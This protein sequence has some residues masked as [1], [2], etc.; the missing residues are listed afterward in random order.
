MRRGISLLIGM[1]LLAGCGL[2]LDMGTQP[3]AETPATLEE[4]EDVVVAEG[5]VEP[6]H[7]SD[8]GFA[9]AGQVV[10]VLVEEGDAVAARD[11]L[12]RLDQADARLAVKQAEA[13]L[14]VAEAQL[15][16]LK[17]GAQPEEIAAAEARLEAAEA[18]VKQATAERDRVVSGATE[19]EIAAA[20]A[21]VA[22]ADTQRK[23]AQDTYDN[24][25]PDEELARYE[26]HAARK[27][28]TAAQAR[29]DDL[30][31]GPDA[32]LF[33][34]VE[35][36]VE[37]AAAERDAVQDQLDLVQAG[38]TEEEIAI[39]EVDVA[40]ARVSL[41]TAHAALADAE[42]QAPFGGTVTAVAVEVGN[43]VMPG[44]VACTLAA[45]DQLQVRTKDLSELDVA[46][47]EPGQ[48]VKVTVDALPEREFDGVVRRVALQAEDFRGEAVFAVTVD[49]V[50]VGDAPPK[51]GMTA[52]VEFEGP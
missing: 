30:R 44:Q 48:S 25:P 16:L 45:V 19:A 28:L 46:G 49:L 26:L 11:V 10:E 4:S 39:A 6:A 12:V 50:D 34:A 27:A 18:A 20:S 22:S 47:I 13:D 24:D 42:V 17:A 37:A 32:N 21:E 1:L 40:R 7:W 38:P 31:A 41:E 5:L 15:A 36:G 14:E 23:V 33:R 35:A 3:T 43:A 8:L 52:W 9:A 29:L 51:W 2:S